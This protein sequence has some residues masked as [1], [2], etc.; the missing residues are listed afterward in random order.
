MK[1][2]R[3]ISARVPAQTLAAA[4]AYTGAGAS[5][6]I[7]IALERLARESFYERFRAHRGKVNFDDFRLDELRRDREFDEHGNVI[8]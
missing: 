7:R 4:E 3:K 5:A 2:A 1:D 8:G 6:T